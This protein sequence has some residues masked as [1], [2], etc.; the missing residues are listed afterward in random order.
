MC[1]PPLRSALLPC[2]ALKVG[3]GVNGLLAVVVAD[4]SGPVGRDAEGV[5]GL[6]VDDLREFLSRLAVNGLA[7]VLEAVEEIKQGEHIDFRNAYFSHKT[8][9]GD[10]HGKCDPRP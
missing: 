3:D 7:P 8:G 4:A 10:D 5:V 1:L 6:C 9:G 2:H